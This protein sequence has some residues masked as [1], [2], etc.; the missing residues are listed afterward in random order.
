VDAKMSFYGIPTYRSLKN[1]S[2]LPKWET[3]FVEDIENRIIRHPNKSLSINQLNKL[4]DIFTPATDKQKNHMMK[5]G[6]TEEETEVT[7]RQASSLIQAKQDGLN[8]EYE[9]DETGR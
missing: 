5:L 6:F 3:R 1:N 9:V 8:S 2:S 4:W 7:K